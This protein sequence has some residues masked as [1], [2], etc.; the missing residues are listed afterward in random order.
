MTIP[1]HLKPIDWAEL[2]AKDSGPRGLMNVVGYY[3]TEQS[4]ATALGLSGDR[5]GDRCKLARQ[6]MQAAAEY[7]EMV[8]RVTPPRLDELVEEF[9]HVASQRSVSKNL[10][11]SGIP[12]ATC[13][14]D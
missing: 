12:A 4:V 11:N 7:L 6:N 8:H 13:R 5:D 2:E 1:L 10:R 9:T 14:N 3:Q